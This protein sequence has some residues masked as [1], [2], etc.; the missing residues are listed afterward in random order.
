MK[1]SIGQVIAK[2]MSSPYGCVY[3]VTPDNERSEKATLSQPPG[4]RE[5]ALQN[6]AYLREVV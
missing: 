2:R 1:Q 3:D 6:L 4:D 5:V